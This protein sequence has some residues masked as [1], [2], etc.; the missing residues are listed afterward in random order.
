MACTEVSGW[1]WS[2]DCPAGARAASAQPREHDM[3]RIEAT[4]EEIADARAWAEDCSWKDEGALKDYSDE[5]IVRGVN[6]HYDGGWA[7]FRRA[8]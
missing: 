1:R 8:R 6:R 7:G 3:A 5:E 4:P 2:F